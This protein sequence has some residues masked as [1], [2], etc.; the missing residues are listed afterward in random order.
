MQV[1]LLKKVGKL[2][3]IGDVVVVKNGYAR[4]F[5][6]PQKMALR[7][8]ESN[9]GYFTAKRAE[10][11]ESNLKLKSEAGV[12]AKKMSGTSITLVRQA[13]ESGFLFGSVRSSDIAGELSKLGYSVEKSQILMDAPVKA[14]GTYNIRISLHP[15]VTS[16]ISLRVMTIQEQIADSAEPTEETE[17]EPIDEEAQDA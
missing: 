4:N 3:T 17:D 7:A 5:L 1:V 15:E 16:D 12:L 2:G 9:L 8:T 13:S 10:I 14:I 11:E 6:L